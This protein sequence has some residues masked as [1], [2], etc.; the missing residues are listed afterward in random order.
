VSLTFIEHFTKYC[1][2]LVYQ[3]IAI[4]LELDS[5]IIPINSKFMHYFTPTSFDKTKIEFLN[6][7]FSEKRYKHRRKVFLHHSSLT[8]YKFSSSLLFE[9][10]R[11]PPIP[12]KSSNK[13]MMEHNERQISSYYSTIN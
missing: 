7:T 3:T 13:N 10:S 9:H 6:L 12:L 1:V 5:E 11:K 4:K 2:F 8:F